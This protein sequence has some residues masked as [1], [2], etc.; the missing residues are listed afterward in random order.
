MTAAAASKA[1]PRTAVDMIASTPAG[2]GRHAYGRA[3]KKAVDARRISCILSA[4]IRGSK[5]EERLFLYLQQSLE[6]FYCHRFSS[7]SCRFVLKMLA[8]T[9]R[10]EEMCL[11]RF[12]PKIKTLKVSLISFFICFGTGQSR[13]SFPLYRSLLAILLCNSH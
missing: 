3:R 2:V 9:T 6:H 4:I 8:N 7:S 5:R 12:H 1:S 10:F 13:Q 11:D